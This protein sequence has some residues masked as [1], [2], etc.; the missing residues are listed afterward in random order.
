M[1][2]R[3][4]YF[5]LP[6]GGA[7][8]FMPFPAGADSSTGD[9]ELGDTFSFGLGGFSAPHVGEVCSSVMRCVRLILLLGSGWCLAILFMTTV[10]NHHA[11]VFGQKW[12]WL[13]A[14]MGA[15]IGRR[16]FF[17][18]LTCAVAALLQFG[19]LTCITRLPAM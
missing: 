15:P 4:Q 11:P 3:R 18:R 8:P 7:D 6:A 1:S 10:D 19:H 9:F 5:P 2:Q 17:A 12:Q 13:L 14:G 16:W